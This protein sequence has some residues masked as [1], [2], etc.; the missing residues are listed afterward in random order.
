MSDDRERLKDVCFR[1]YQAACRAIDDPKNAA[2]GDGRQETSWT[3]LD[4]DLE[5]ENFNLR[6]DCEAVAQGFVRHYEPD[7]E[8]KAG[9]SLVLIAAMIDKA[10]R[11]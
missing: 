9:N 3:E 7:P 6:M 2:K 11:A 4:V 1:V 10:E 8:G 5:D